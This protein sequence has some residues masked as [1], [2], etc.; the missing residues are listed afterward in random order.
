[1]AYSS[2]YIQFRNFDTNWVLVVDVTSDKHQQ[3]KPFPIDMFDGLQYTQDQDTSI[4]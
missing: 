3:Q 4:P 1:M 2:F